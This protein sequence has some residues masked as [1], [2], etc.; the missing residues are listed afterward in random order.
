VTAPDVSVTGETLDPERKN[1][2]LFNVSRI[3]FVR[4]YEEKVL[5]NRMERLSELEPGWWGPDSDPP[6]ADV[7]ER[8]QLVVD[9]FASAGL[10]VDFIPTSD[11]S[12]VAEWTRGHVEYS[13][14]LSEAGRLV[15]I[16]DNTKT[17]ELRE[18]E[19]EFEPRLLIEF[20]ERG[21]VP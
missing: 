21:I 8:L 10:P 1:V 2:H 3:E 15:L 17:D 19:V 9:R 20:L 12:I 5:V 13:A 18:A 7:L 11:G 4:S 16:A 14:T 6:A